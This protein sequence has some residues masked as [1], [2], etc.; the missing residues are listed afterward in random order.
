MIRQAVLEYDHSNDALN[1]LYS[2]IGNREALVLKG[3]N[4]YD[5]AV[6]VS[7]RLAEVPSVRFNGECSDEEFKRLKAYR[8][9]VWIAVG[10]GKLI[11][12]AKRIAFT[13]LVPLI[14]I[15]TLV[16]NCAAFTPLSVIYG[17]DG[18]YLRYDTFPV[19]IERVIVDTRL[20]RD[21]P[22][23]YFRAGVIDTVAKWFE[24]R[25]ISGTT[26]RDAGIQSGLSLAAQCGALMDLSIREDDFRR[27]DTD[28]RYI[29]D[30]VLAIGGA[31]GG[32]GD[33]GT[34][35]AVAHAVHNA[36][37]R[38]DS[39]HHWLH[40]D[41]VGFGLIV[42]ERLASS[43]DASFLEN[44]LHAIAAPT[45]LEQLGIR[46]DQ[47]DELVDYVIEEMSIQG[48]RKIEDAGR[49]KDFFRNLQEMVYK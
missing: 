3:I 49:L 17:E 34:R 23:D 15:P 30:H 14:V 13:Q 16:S 6:R 12:T 2:L 43:K 35:V 37:S 31:V 41:K 11:D 8:P 32:F 19:V 28:I 33:A 38:F 1:K 7:P 21:S 47:V 46:F 40:G 4:G 5:E 42:Q 44:W 20:L 24:A 22:Y 48:I 36:L 27:Y 45:S 29:V 39:T 25:Y 10:G 18:T 26:S 9:D